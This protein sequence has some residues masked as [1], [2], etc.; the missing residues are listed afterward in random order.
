MHSQTKA[1]PKSSKAKTRSLTGKG[2]DDPLF[3]GTWVPVAKP[4]SGSTTSPEEASTLAEMAN[5]RVLLKDYETE[6][7]RT[8][9]DCIKMHSRDAEQLRQR[10]AEVEAQLNL[11]MAKSQL[12]MH[13]CNSMKDLT[14]R[15]LALSLEQERRLASENT[16]LKDELR[17]LKD[18]CLGNRSRSTHSSRSADGRAGSSI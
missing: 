17:M 14:M 13:E 1:K 16:A 10:L 15:Q 3:Q 9:L 18:P 8:S 2:E 12:H 11:E 5:L 7:I 4:L 6:S